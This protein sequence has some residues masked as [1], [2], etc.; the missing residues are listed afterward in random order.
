ME[1]NDKI[2]IDVELS[3]N[4]KNQIASLT[5][6][7]NLL[8]NTVNGIA[9]P[10]N[11]IS[12]NLNTLSNSISKYSE[13]ISKAVDQTKELGKTGGDT[14]NKVSDMISSFATWRGI[15]D[16]VAKGLTGM[17]AAL[18][19]GLVILTTFAP[20]IIK[21]VSSLFKGKDAIDQAKMS[22]S[23]LNQALEDTDYSKAIR[24]VSELKINIGL[25]KNGFIDKKKV[26]NQYNETIGK[27]MGQ[28]NNLNDAENKLLK[29]GD[30]Y[31]KMTL[32]KATA[33]LALQDAAKKAYEAEQIKLKTDD[34][35]LTFWDKLVDIANRNAGAAGPGAPGAIDAWKQADK[36]KQRMAKD[37]RKET[38]TEINKQKDAFL[39]IAKNFQQ[40]A[41]ELAKQSGFDFFNGTQTESNNN[42]KPKRKIIPKPSSKT[43]SRGL[44]AIETK[45]M[46]FTKSFALDQQHYEKEQ[47]LLDDQL[48]N[49]LISEEAYQQKSDQLKDQ[50]HQLVGNKVRNFYEIDLNEAQKHLENLATIQKHDSVM[51]QDE[52]DLKKAIL[53]GDQLKAEQTLIDHKYAYEIALA[54]GNKEK[55]K[56]LEEE[57]E[58][59]KTEIA[60]RYEEQRKA[61]ALQTAQKV[62]DNAFSILKGNIQSQADAKIKGLETQKQAELN[63]S[64]LTANQKRAIEDKYKKKEAEEKVKAF[65]AEQRASIL[66]AVINGA[67]AITKATSQTGVLAPFVIPGI[68]VETALQVA[69]IAK[70]KA[71]QYGKG[72]VHYQSDGRGALLS[73]YSRTDDTNAYLRSGEAVVVSEAMRN[74]WARNLVS[75]INVAHGGR[76]FSIGN[77]GRGYAIGG[78]FTD[79]GNA[80]RYYSAPANDAKDLAN[81]LAYQM[82][83]NFPPIYVDVKD[84]N[85]QQNILA[86]TVNRV[87]L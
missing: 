60:Q 25:A 14:S 76:D 81:T 72:G 77:P 47:A 38:L 78:I 64:S 31:I 6:S 70:Q 26:L 8:K 18:T 11:N 22:I 3:G 12:G 46:D 5:E 66:Q 49:K 79:G 80:N 86:Q 43:T 73:G 36:D 34:E 50:F 62:S 21:F 10:L 4:G 85:N 51:Q 83:N 24:Q 44:E 33:Q 53:P 87:N 75:A 67:L 59:E 29:N 15:I 28:V 35:S 40:K 27:T 17:E 16:L 48:K 63:N 13:S 58:K 42:S 71:P 69:T 20:E 57:K 23:N 56:Q 19:G 82:I 2:S 68:I 54:E 61:F 1:N 52:H 9:A 55:I 7:L 32:Y 74:P 30:A 39:D 37:N 41:S 65:K 84:V 45:A